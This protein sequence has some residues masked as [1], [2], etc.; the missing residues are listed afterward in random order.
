[1]NDP[2][3][4]CR[5][6]NCGR[7]NY[8][9]LPL[10][11]CLL[12]LCL[13]LLSG[14]MTAM[15]KMP[16]T[17][18]DIVREY[19]YIY[20]HGNY[21]GMK[22]TWVHLNEGDTCSI[23]ATGSVDTAP[24]RPPGHKDRDVRPE[25]GPRFMV[26][27]GKN[28]FITP[29]SKRN[30]VSITA[31]NTGD[32]FL[33]I[34]DGPVN[35]YGNSLNPKCY[36][37]NT[38]LFKVLVIVWHTQDWTR[39]AEVFHHLQ[40]I[41]PENKAVTDAM[42]PGNRLALSTEPLK[43]K[44]K[45]KARTMSL[46]E[47]KQ[48]TLSM[49]KKPFVPPPRS[50]HDILDL[51]DQPGDFDTDIARMHE[52]QANATP[53]ATNDPAIL[54]EFYL[55]RGISARDLGRSTQEL[56]D[57][58]T[59]LHYAETKDG[60][61]IAGLAERSY[62]L[63]LSHLGISEMNFGNYRRAVALQKKVLSRN[64]ERH[65][66]HF[67]LTMMQ[68]EMGD[69]KS[70]EET[71]DAGV[72]SCNRAI[73][74]GGVTGMNKTWALLHKFGMQAWVLEAQ[75][76]Y[77]E[78]EEVR[79]AFLAYMN[80]PEIKSVT[81]ISAPRAYFNRRHYMT[82]NLRNQG[83]Y[84]EAELEA[85]E[86]LKE[87]IGLSGIHSETTGK[88]L[89]E[90]GSIYYSQG[91]INDAETIFKEAYRITEASGTSPGS[92]RMSGAKMNLGQV[93]VAG[94]D[95]AGAMR[96]FD[97]VKEDMRDDLSFYERI[98][99]RNSDLILSQIK[100]GRIEKAMKSIS[101][102]HD[103]YREQYGTDRYDTAELQGLRGMVHAVRGND[104]EALTDFSEALPILLSKRR[105]YGKDLRLNIIVEA[106]LDLLTR[107]HSEKQEKTFGIDV[108]A[109]IFRLCEAMNGSAVQG[110][111]S[112]SGARAAAVEP[113]LADLV[114]KE[115]D[116]FKQIGALQTTLA[117]V[118]A[119]PS[120][121]Q[122]PVAVK[123][124][125]ETIT[126]LQAARAS[127]REEIT[128]RFPKYA[129]FTDPQPADFSQV[130]G[131]LKP[132][133]AM[134]VI[135]PKA[136]R[137]YTWAIPKTGTVSFSIADLDKTTLQQSVSQ[138]RAALDVA[139]QTFGDIPAFDCDSAY[140]LYR[141]LLQPVEAGWGTAKDL[142]VVAPGPL[143]HLPFSVLP[144]GPVK[145]APQEREL[146]A[147]YRTVPWLIRKSAIVRQPSVASFVS[148]RSLPVADSARKAFVGFGD[149]L[150]NREQLAAAEKEKAESR[151]MLAAL[152]EKIGDKIKVRSIRI[153]PTG[154]LDS[155][156][157]SSCNLGMLCRIPDTAEEIK[158]IA[159][160]LGAD[161]ARDIFLGKDASEHTVKT[162]DLSNSRVVAFASHAL[163]PGD[164]DGLDQPAIALSAPSVTGD[165]EDGLLKM[166]EILR[167]KLNADWVILS[168]CN[169]GAAEGSGAEAVSGLGRAFFYAG[170]RAILVSMWPVETT[171]AR[172]LTTGLF[173]CQ[174]ENINLKRVQAH[175][176]S[177]LALIDSPGFID[178]TTDKIVASYAH[179][180][181]WAP[182]I[183]VGEGR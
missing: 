176:Q 88:L 103:I 123:D 143:A 62:S 131:L 104:R 38:G 156:A 145:A 15:I 165:G 109:E 13:L 28:P 183:I 85:R 9:T 157:L 170:T 151:I 169:T 25:H 8:Q 74:Y 70:A 39:I 61:K 117:N 11:C 102:W 119:A 43:A 173:R 154:S 134:V 80:Q 92:W 48:V 30:A 22:N 95:F 113:E 101:R 55:K 153:T 6:S 168:A 126:T 94:Q 155:D 84:M 116:A 24:N 20:L 19:K 163:V 99:S 50:I 53:P 14:C 56:E 122:D 133:E 115:Q 118:I 89:R 114:R 5:T 110:A 142:I 71:K 32:L 41:N 107:I 146:F 90:L 171:S 182:F 130:Q 150:F 96:H 16:E 7:N 1:M 47:A 72:Q 136:Q 58:R 167:L 140:G 125:K 73:D 49:S 148:M 100:S 65:T 180:V 31:N 23:F 69:L 18:P 175:R 160:L 93:S 66:S 51:L 144:T 81:L 128:R 29:L 121:Q 42:K 127:L 52:E 159:T 139:P 34:K 120:D 97:E 2:D 178:K 26:R 86:T 68:V 44:A 27:I 78:A 132:G 164:L 35:T 37:S 4:P 112:E 124:M 98:F 147:K 106:Y 83:R 67:L 111:L 158:N 177:M 162:M 172:K 46:D 36:K 174:K 137:T 152:D 105:D 181:F 77:A 179:P 21:P 3:M 82:Q 75:G 40:E 91:R 60:K 141:N 12:M 87:S 57:F 33:G 108:A 45:A 166:E 17:Q 64:P 59:A 135:Y 63:I 138:L 149:P 129:E 161:P 76:K 54:A 10:S 79:R